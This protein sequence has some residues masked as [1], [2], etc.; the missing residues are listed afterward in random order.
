MGGSA[1]GRAAAEAA[2]GRAAAFLKLPA[3]HVSQDHVLALGAALEVPAA[4]T[5]PSALP[6]A[7][8]QHA[9]EC[10]YFQP[11]SSTAA[12]NRASDLCCSICSRCVVVLHVL[13]VRQALF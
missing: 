6:P 3:V 13:H 9:H 4:A 8:F 10:W 2:V 7:Q 11:V 12:R 5:A 1:A